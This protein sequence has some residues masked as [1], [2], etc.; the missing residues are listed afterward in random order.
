MRTRT[1]RT[2]IIGMSMRAGHETVT[3]RLRPRE[4]ERVRVREAG[5]TTAAPVAL[6]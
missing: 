6:P 4:R 2:P 3:D 5:L 1:C